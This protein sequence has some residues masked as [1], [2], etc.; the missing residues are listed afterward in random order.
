MVPV[1]TMDSRLLEGIAAG[2][3]V[4][5]SNDQ[6][7][8]VGVGDTMRDALEAAQKQDEKDPFIIRKPL[9]NTSLIL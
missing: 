7:R 5:I 6:E 2:K 8:V 3:W 1:K 9:Q 4:A